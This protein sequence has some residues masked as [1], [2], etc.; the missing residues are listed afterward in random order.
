[1]LRVS[2][3]EKMW[4][5]FVNNRTRR[6][7]AVRGSAKL[8]YRRSSPLRLE[9][10]ED[11]TV[12]ASIVVNSPL[13]VLF[14]AKT[15]TISTVRGSV[16]SL[17]DA[18][19]IA[20]NTPGAD[21]IV[22]TAFQSYNLKNIDNYW[23]G[24][25]GLP[26][27]SSDITIQGNGAQINRTG[28][29][30]FRI[31][32]VSNVQYGGL[33]TGSL[34]LQGLTIQGGFAVGGDS[35]RGGGGLGA[36]GAIFNQGNLV[37]DGVLMM[38]NTAQGGT[39][40]GS[41][42]LFAGGGIG[43]DAPNHYVSHAGGG[44]GGPTPGSVNFATGGPTREGQGGKLDGSPDPFARAG[45]GGGGLSGVTDA[46]GKTGGF[47]GGGGGDFHGNPGL[48]GFGGGIGAD[49]GPYWYP[50]R[51]RGGGGAGLGGAVFNRGGNV[52]II[53][54]TITNNLA[55]GGDG[56]RYVALYR[57]PSGAGSGFG[58]GVF[59][60]NGTVN[61]TNS[62]IVQNSVAP[63]S[64]GYYNGGGG[65]DGRADGNQ[66]Y[67]LADSL[68]GATATANLIMANTILSGASSGGHDLVNQTFTNAANNK[69]S[70]TNAA[71]VNAATNIISTAIA[72]YD[73]NFAPGGTGTVSVGYSQ[74]NPQLNGLNNNGGW[75]LTMSVGANSPAKNGGL[76]TA[77]KGAN[78]T[79]LSFDGRGAPYERA[80]GTQ[81]DIGA[82][83]S[84]QYQLYPNIARLGFYD[85][86]SKLF[87]PFQADH[88]VSNS[89]TT[90]KNVYVIS[91][92]WMPG[93]DGWV[94]G[95]TQ[96]GNLPLSWQTWQGP[97]TTKSSDIST[98]WL[99]QGSVANYS[100]FQVNE[101]GL[102]QSILKVDPDATVIA[103]SWIDESA[104]SS[105]IA[106]PANGWES[107]G[108]TT[109]A[110]LQLAEG[111]MEALDPNFYK[112][113]GKVH[114]IGH[115]HG[116]RVVAVAAVALQKAAKDNVQFNVVRQ[117]TLLDSPEDNS[118]SFPNQAG[119]HAGY[120]GNPVYFED[121]AN[122]NWF[123]LAQLDMAQF[124]VQSGTNLTGLYTPGSI[125][126]DSYISQ[127]GSYF[128]NFQVNAAAFNIKDK[129]LNNVI[130]TRLDPTQI[131]WQDLSH[132]FGIATNHQYS[133]NWYAGSA[134]TKGTKNQTGLFWSP[135]IKGSTTPIS[136][137]SSQLWASV[138]SAHQFVLTPQPRA[139][140]AKPMFST[141]PITYV[142]QSGNVQQQGQWT[143]V[144]LNADQ[145]TASFTGTFN[146]TNS[147]TVGFAFS[148]DFAAGS[149][150][151]AQLQIL[152]NGQ[153][154]FSLDA[155]VALGLP[156]GNQ[157]SATFG[158][159]SEGVGTQNIQIQLVKNGTGTPTKVTVNNFHV[160]T[161]S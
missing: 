115:S 24:P 55:R 61:L 53:N 8:Q 82:F 138:D 141:A 136:R 80:F 48:G 66:V 126:V 65:F 11:R 95:Y 99:Y 137:Q 5:G 91:H 161:L 37:L 34:T 2:L 85:P 114:L 19:N 134:S 104:T 46:A 124:G 21:T 10:L 64:S 38:N 125:F 72:N 117:L 28:G 49:Y 39:T 128:G 110:G 101:A 16:I 68:N 78:G 31:F 108:R 9:L 6:T 33:A 106:I 96:Q 132:G 1:M 153:L 147:S 32:Y 71:G 12:P 105:G 50:L 152:L 129:S 51:V 102:A 20:N 140:T 26:A 107:E 145:G 52:S 22:L 160:F 154:Y 127:V 121:T 139:A 118:Q 45:F 148:Y 100:K 43:G 135:L 54:S 67:N 57:A 87:L 151:G 94:S 23:Y 75:T 25:N 159:G 30:N 27:I 15:A 98:P 42:D 133:A 97:N 73:A 29:P 69:A 155:K 17:T 41:I 74:V 143:G 144:I 4:A 77:A 13:D 93:L 158:I 60:L 59:N 3:F 63:G 44:F 81:I 142:S 70:V 120:S 157:F 89:D 113:L 149:T 86:A 40:N 131:Y 92:G 103:F 58:G 62:T 35:F 112:G 150:D 79:P 88:T 130:D 14:Q 18:I 122:F 156:G 83:Q 47:G 111:L 123:N 119:G 90:V 56:A 116:S 76:S 7:R 84:Q 36:G 109:M 146:R